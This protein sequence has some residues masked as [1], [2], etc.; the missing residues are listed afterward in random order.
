MET[1]T[2]TPAS[3]AE[4][5]LIATPNQLWNFFVYVR[6]RVD[7]LGFGVLFGLGLAVGLSI[8]AVMCWLFVH[9]FHIGRMS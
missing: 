2:G 3:P 8:G 9:Y 1:R 6:E 7:N 4:K 5:P